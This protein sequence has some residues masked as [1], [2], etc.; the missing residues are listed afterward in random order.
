MSTKRFVSPEFPATTRVALDADHAFIVSSGVVRDAE[1]SLRAEGSTV[2][3]GEPLSYDV[4]AGPAAFTTS[5]AD[6]L[7]DATV[8]MAARRPW[9]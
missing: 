5:A 6:V 2:N 8:R 9:L 4:S 3:V 7:A 1:G